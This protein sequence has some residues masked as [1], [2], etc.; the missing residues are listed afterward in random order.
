MPRKITGLF[1][2]IPL[3]ASVGTVA[4]TEDQEFDG[5]SI[6]LDDV[7][8]V[9]EQSLQNQFCAYFIDVEKGDSIL[10]KGEKTILIDGGE[11]DRKNPKQILTILERNDKEFVD[12]DSIV[13]THPDKDHY[14]GLL[15]LLRD[16]QKI[17]PDTGDVPFVLK[18]VK[19]YYG[20]LE[21]DVGT[22][23][24]E[25]RDRWSDQRFEYDNE[26]LWRDKK[27]I[28]ISDDVLMETLFPIKD[29]HLQKSDL[30]TMKEVYEN[31]PDEFKDAKKMG[32]KDEDYK[33]TPHNANSLVFRISYE[34]FSMLL[35]GDAEATTE[36]M[37][38]EHYGSELKSDV[39]KI[40]H[41]GGK[42][43]SVPQF[44]QA[45]N[46]IISIVTADEKKN[47]HG[48]PSEWALESYENQGSNVYQTGLDGTIEICS[49]GKSF[50][51]ETDGSRYDDGYLDSHFFVIL[52][53]DEYQGINFTLN[54]TDRDNLDPL[55]QIKHVSYD[56]Q[57]KTIL[58]EFDETDFEGSV[59]YTIPNT[60]L[61]DANVIGD[62]GVVG[63]EI[64]YNEDDIT[65]TVN[66]EVGDDTTIIVGVTVAEDT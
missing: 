36:Y 2:L 35:A 66:H 6:P 14:G 34:Q 42:Y 58:I 65:I 13:L 25:F 37:L 59:T 54:P 7:I 43:S 1:A 18:D 56:E 50:L 62:E 33:G 3:L 48:H 12:L 16:D 61:K 57:Y 29:A 47:S 26:V 55:M 41:H 46:P 51:V 28:R 24:Q 64:S 21:R 9:H 17:D 23:L 53:D 19:R 49:D 44:V 32:L 31:Y 30:M 5:Q 4:L 22:Y 11:L 39:V 20:N 27:V 8:Q 52:D 63:Y 40:S 60:L 38:A 15:L 10:L 45:T